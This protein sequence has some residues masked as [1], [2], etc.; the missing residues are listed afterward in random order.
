MLIKFIKETHFRLNSI[1]VNKRITRSF[2]TY[3]NFWIYALG[4]VSKLFYKTQFDWFIMMSSIISLVHLKNYQISSH[5][6][7]KMVD[8]FLNDPM[9]FLMTSLWTNQNALYGIIWRQ[10]LSVNHC[11][12]L[13]HNSP[14]K[15]PILSRPIFRSRARIGDSNGVY[16]VYIY[17]KL[18]KIHLF[19][20]YGV[21]TELDKMLK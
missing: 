11:S 1:K 6:I 2:V 14:E 8:N 18:H 3:K 4:P 12:K 21:I 7:T 5:V 20:F 13:R 19:H 16:F 10:S 9:K 17:V 15:C